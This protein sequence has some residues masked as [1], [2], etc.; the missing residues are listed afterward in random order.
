MGVYLYPSGTET[1][2]K[3]VYI[4]SNSWQPWANTLAYYT[5][6]DQ[7][8]NQITDV[9]NGYNLTGW[10][11]P[12]YTLVGGTNYAWNYNNQ[13]TGYGSSGSSWSSIYWNYINTWIT[14]VLWIKISA[15][16]SQ[17]ITM[18][19]DNSNQISIIY[20]YSSGKIEIFG[21]NR[22]TIL[23]NT[24]LDT[25]YCAWITR[26]NSKVNTYINGTYVW[27]VSTTHTQSS[28]TFFIGWTWSGKWS[29]ND[30]FHWQIWEC[31][32]EQWMWSASD[33]LDYYNRT[34][35]NYGIS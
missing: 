24:Q 25:W 31:V 15:A 12:T 10:T 13:S 3:N 30:R 2:L 6:D 9:V 14:L 28:S 21:D 17:Y 23:S 5:F 19:N 16:G 35:W 22:S 1:E 26:G 27:Q 29:V 11:M 20:G 32:I 4:W 7:N 18:W 34:K 8:A 33:F